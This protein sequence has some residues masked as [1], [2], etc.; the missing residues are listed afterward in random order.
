MFSRVLGSLAALALIFASCDE[1]DKSAEVVPTRLDLLVRGPDSVLEEP[2][3]LRPLADAEWGPLGG[4]GWREASPALALADGTLYVETN[5]PSASLRLP[6]TETRERELSITLWR[7]RSAPGTSGQVRLLLNGRQIDERVLPDT[8]T[9]IAIPTA[10]LLW[11]RGDNALEFET[12]KVEKPGPERWDTLAVSSVSYGSPRLTSFD[13]GAKRYTLPHG[14][15]LR[16]S[17]EVSAGA[18]LLVRGTGQ[19]AGELQVSLAR[20]DPRSGDL[21]PIGST[22]RFPAEGLLERAIALPDPSGALLALEIAWHSPAA[23]SFRLEKL[24]VDEPR[25][26]PRPPIVFVSIDTFSARHLSLYGYR[27]RTTPELEEFARD[28]VV[29]ERCVA[30][31]PW[32]MP[33]YLSVMTGLYP[34]AHLAEVTSSPLVQLDNYD[35]WQVADSRWTLAEALR[36]R[37]YQTAAS[38]DT[39]WLSPRFR[40]DQGFDLYDLEPA[41]QPFTDPYYGIAFILERLETWLDGARDPSAPF[42]VFLH[43]LDAHGPYWP[44]PPYRGTFDTD[45]PEDPRPTAAGSAPMTYGAIPVWMARTSVPD[46]TQPIPPELGLEPIVARYDEALLK[47]DAYLGK[48]FDLLRERGI[49]DEAVILVSGDHGESF[50]H[51]LYSHGCLWEDIVHVPLLLKLPRGE[52]GGERV[53]T[54]VQLVDVYPTLL[55]LAGADGGRDWLHGR[56]LMRLLSSADHPPRPTFSQGGH[57]EQAMVEQEGWKLVELE[58]GVR[59]G[60]PQLLTHPRTPRAWLET[61]F[62]E[63][64]KSIPS[65]ALFAELRARG[66]FYRKFGQLQQLVRGPYYELYDLNTDP[67]EL[68]DLAA[69]R[70]EV[71]E[72]LR[73]LLEEHKARTR[74][75]QKDAHPEIRPQGFSPEELEALEDLGYIGK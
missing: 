70:P 53:A 48:L 64:L 65:D 42:F 66:D 20:L 5:Q 75:A 13:R 34:G 14:T 6:A 39:H 47:T 35:F 60:E 72:R 68:H 3:E 31:A 56:S 29:F 58:P 28:A 71:V 25:A 41:L 50:D 15:G 27:R 51:G 63:L 9:T 44:E 23:A 61:N 73:R 49:Y 10:A 17:I 24:H 8:P 19:G 69:E 55:E 12:P 33:S 62:P 1:A 46:E 45:L 26:S 7:A 11:K 4:P 22:T 54:S 52:H 32:T 30:N 57:I 38:V 59:P 67:L 37:G 16:Y 18:R 2:G 36:A 21:A 40:I 43:A 74:A